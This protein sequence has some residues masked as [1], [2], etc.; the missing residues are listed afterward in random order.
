MTEQTTGITAGEVA[1]AA[2]TALLAQID[3][4]T[5]TANDTTRAAL[6]GL[7]ALVIS[8][9]E[10]II[11]ASNGMIDSENALHDHLNAARLELSD[12]REQHN[13]LKL[14]CSRL[15]AARRLDEDKVRKIEG[16]NAQVANQR[17]AYKRDADEWHR[18][19]PELK[20][21]RERLKRLE[22]AGVKRETEHNEIKMKLQRTESLLMRAALGV[23]QAK[24]AIQNCQQR[25]LLEGLEA[26]Q[27]M[28]VKGVYYYIYRRPCAVAQT[29]KPTD[30][31][32]VSR[33]HMYAF[34]VETSAGYHWDAIPLQD[35][36]VGIVKQRAMP[37]AVKQYL[38]DQYKQGALFDFE[39]A[40][41]RSK[42]LG[43][44]LG[45]LGVALAELDSIDHSLTQLKVKDSL[46]QTRARK[47]T[48][49][50]GRRAA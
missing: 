34:R 30:E 16:A 26:E 24:E 8:N 44:G 39:K 1:N 35:G 23:V 12:E 48:N 15:I 49:A 31:Q 32:I 7:R 17:D 4:L 47:L 10:A 41:L 9:A 21:L 25:M 27:T 6:Q 29:F 43:N 50:M 45:D 40:S 33:D 19:K 18:A 5:N 36:D 28:E 42:D 3:L 11:T 37:A 2:A 20:K 46:Q 13:E 38:I 22:E 14:Q